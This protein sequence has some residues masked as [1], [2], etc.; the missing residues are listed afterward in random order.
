MADEIPDHDT[1][2]IYIIIQSEEHKGFRRDGHNLHTSL[3]ISLKDA[4]FGFEKTIEHLDNH[5]VKLERKEVTQPEFV[6][7]IFDEGMPIVDE[8]GDFTGR[9]GSLFVRYTVKLPSSVPTGSFK[10][11]LENILRPT[12]QYDEL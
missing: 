1:G 5:R 8:D 12:S 2:D 9:R 3:E 7:E 4:L 10:Q 6:H 11:D